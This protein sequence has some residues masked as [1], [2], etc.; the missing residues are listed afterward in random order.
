M[1]PDFIVH[2]LIFAALFAS[3]MAHGQLN[4]RLRNLERQLKNFDVIPKGFDSSQGS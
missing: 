2:M 4:R 3:L 1:T